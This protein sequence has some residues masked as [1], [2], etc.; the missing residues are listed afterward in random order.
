[1]TPFRPCL[2]CGRLSRAGS[3]CPA[4]TSHTGWTPTRNR[5]AQAR[6]R[7]AVLARDG[8][9]CVICGETRDLRAAHIVSVSRGGSYDPSNGRSLCGVHDRESDRHAR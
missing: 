4:C 5:A 7:K 1:V 8:Y 2:R 9:R 3:Y 6:F